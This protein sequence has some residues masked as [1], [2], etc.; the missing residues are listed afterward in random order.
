ML[1][2]HSAN[3]VFD[4]AQQLTD[5]GLRL[6]VIDESPL[7]ALLNACV[8][9]SMA[10]G[11]ITSVA[12]DTVSSS[13]VTNFIG[14]SRLKGPEGASEH[15]LVMDEL[16]ETI[17]MAVS[18]NLNWARNE[19]APLV[20]SIHDE[21]EK[22]VGEAGKAGPVPLV[23]L[24]YFYASLWDRPEV[25]EMIGRYSNVPFAKVNTL[26]PVALPEGKTAVQ[27][28]STGL[29][30]VDSAVQEIVQKRGESYINNLY[31]LY[32]GKERVKTMD[33]SLNWEQ[34]D[35]SLIVLLLANALVNHVPAGINGSLDSY[36]S[37]MAE[38]IEQA[39]AACAR[40]IR[41][42]EDYDRN[43]TL[44]L[45]LPYG[46][47][48]RGNIFVNGDVYNRWLHEGGTPEIL[49]GAVLA[50]AETSYTA[51]LEDKERLARVFQSMAETLKS[52]LQY[53][54]FNAMLASFRHS[55]TQL[56]MQM[57]ESKLPVD[58]NTLIQNLGHRLTHLKLA[59][60]D[61]IYL[62]ARK[63]LCR[64]LWMHTNVERY[65]RA[66]DAAAESHPGMQVR[67]VALYATIDLVVEWLDAQLAVVSG[68]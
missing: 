61:N 50:N 53:T 6:S 48:R 25:E 19:V 24:P 14:A 55:I 65:L 10:S 57:D 33:F 43:R 66:I 21:A 32:F 44:V 52:Q 7:T 64:T 42:R 31:E 23:V 54:R 18:R 20:M 49:M 17:S 26:Y 9:P 58:R 5:Q 37:Y 46:T 38:V 15:D 56:I 16:V 30:G 62:S 59:D 8:S 2:N 4:L 60:L 27:M 34:V 41:R 3:A 13:P 29:A 1:T 28:L 45:Q 40:V 51:M 11:Q 12:D 67:E 22:A 68:G 35:D 39:A 63:T 36:K 47:P